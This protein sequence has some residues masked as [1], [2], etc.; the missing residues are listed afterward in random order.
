MPESKPKS[1]LSSILTGVL[2]LIVVGGLWFVR[3]DT[4]E[5]KYGAVPIPA[6]R[7][8]RKNLAYLPEDDASIVVDAPI[9]SRWKKIDI[10]E[11]VVDEAR[12]EM[13]LEAMDRY[14]IRRSCLMGTSWFTFTL[15]NQFGFERYHENNLAILDIKRK[16]P[17]RFC[18]FPTLDPTADGNLER[19]VEYVALGADGLKL[20]LGHG[21]A[22][23]KG[24]F[25][26]MPLDDPRMLPIYAF[27]EKT[28]LPIV[29]HINLIEYFDEFVRVMEQFPHL[30]VNVPHFGLHKNTGERL[31]RFEWL[32]QRY[33]NVYTDISFGWYTFHI[34]GMEALAKWRSRSSLFF[35]LHADRI[36]YASD[37]V[38]DPTRTQAYVDATLLSYAQFLEMPAFRLF[39]E[40]EYPMYGLDLG[41]SALKA[42][43]ED[44]PAKFLL[45]DEN[46]NLPNRTQNWPPSPLA[47]LPPLAPEVVPLAPGERPWLGLGEFEWK[48]R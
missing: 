39:L 23:G 9:D 15:D 25:H 2:A 28:Q 46:G 42:I 13:L 47:G 17:D 34:E 27:A 40:P 44:T 12:A 20:Y 33:P 16:H 30:R 35:T 11:H 4:S 7:G 31:R 19:L 38:I 3:N 10:H 45:L 43:Y 5:P 37:L 48:N 14:G 41:E 1:R 8:E 36:M 32:L 6:A 21:A 26:M 29:F 18:A 24:P 22:H